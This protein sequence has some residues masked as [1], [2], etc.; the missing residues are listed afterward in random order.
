MYST[1]EKKPEKALLVGVCTSSQERWHELDRLE[2]LQKL[3]EAAGA[4]VFE[5]VLQIRPSYDPAYLIGKGKAFEI[6]NICEQ[7]GIDVV[8]F[9]Q[10]LSPSQVR[11]LEQI[12]KCKIIDR[13][14]LILDIFAQHAETVEAKIQ[15]ELAQLLYRLPR[16][17]GK[18][19]DLSRLGG[20]IGTRGPGEKKL[21]VDR[22]K[23]KDRIN[24]LK[25]ELEEIE[26]TRELHY[27][28][29][30]EIYK[31]T[32]VGYTN[33]GKSSIM[34]LLTKSNL[35]VEDKP[36]S[37]LDATTRIMH[38][39]VLSKPVVV[40][41]TVGFIED[42][43]HHLIASF[44]A[45]LGVAREADV[46]IHVIDITNEPID[47]KIQTVESV[48]S[49]IGCGDK[50]IIKVFNKT[51]LVIEKNVIERLRSNYPD[52]LFI[53][54]KM[55]IGIEELKNEIIRRFQRFEELSKSSKK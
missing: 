19:I 9:D 7:F 25:R 54:V 35:L 53:S 3:A 41:D 23:I 15:V 2:E 13:T 5:K 16:L 44:K 39:E 1:S 37:T 50:P 47:K 4:T 38:Q 10:D 32:L 31:V 40:S 46:L 22:R 27:R 18:G 45:T 36:F 8:I 48:L 49:D 34:N 51:D 24:H 26:K 30:R 43:P 11:N 28:R 6:Q 42:I 29:R 55:K 20:G 33:S 21:E 14:E 52:A 12:I 17:A